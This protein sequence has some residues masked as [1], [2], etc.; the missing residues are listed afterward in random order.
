LHVMSKERQRR[1]RK[2][3]RE[4]PYLVERHE[5]ETSNKSVLVQNKN[6]A[7]VNLE[8]KE[9][10]GIGMVI[11]KKVDKEQ[12]MKIF[13]SG[14]RELTELDSSG[15]K[16]F[17]FIF[18][19]CSN[20]IGKDR[21]WLSYTNE[22]ISESM[23]ES[24]FRKGIKSLVDKK[25]IAPCI[26]QGWYWINPTYIFNGDRLT[27]VKQYELEKQQEPKEYH[28]ETESKPTYHEA[29]QYPLPHMDPNPYSE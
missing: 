24:T 16:V 23:S 20:A 12:F 1:G 11:K 4:N 15:I 8:T 10:S 19:A 13:A 7:M 27:M 18:D 5:I 26:E 21:I 6:M 9:M 22:G 2:L 14:I 25:F 3:Y 29:E 17:R 28:L